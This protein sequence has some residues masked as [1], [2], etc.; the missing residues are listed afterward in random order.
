MAGCVSTGL[1]V[2]LWSPRDMPVGEADK[3]T[4]YVFLLSDELT[5]DHSDVST[6]LIQNQTLIHV[7]L[8][9]PHLLQ[10]VSF[11]AVVTQ[12]VL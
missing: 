10:S 4:G 5:R 3:E 7:L 8:L 2:C 1:L 11:L 12:P 9:G 6:Q